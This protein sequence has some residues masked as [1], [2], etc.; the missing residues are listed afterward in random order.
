M[1]NEG[2]VKSKISW[3]SGTRKVVRERNYSFDVAGT[4]NATFTQAIGTSAEQVVFPAAMASVGMVMLINHDAT[5]YV[6]IGHWNAAS[7]IYSGKILAGEEMRFR[8]SMGIT[9]LAAKANTAGIDL[10]VVS[11]ET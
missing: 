8:L 9:D 1:A 5:N 7:P 6:E 11:L 3:T 4:D 10:E 2:S